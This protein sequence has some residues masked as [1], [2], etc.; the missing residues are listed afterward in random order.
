MVGWRNDRK[1]SVSEESEQGDGRDLVSEQWAGDWKWDGSLGWFRAEERCGLMW[2]L[3]E[4]SDGHW[5]G[6]SR[7][8]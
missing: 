5:R 8:S 6:H 7:S 1:T 4:S 3:R 2:E